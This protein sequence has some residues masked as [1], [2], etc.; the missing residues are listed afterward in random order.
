MRRLPHRKA[1][2]PDGFMAEFLQRCW[3]IVKGDLMAAFAKLFTINGRGFQGLN[4]ALLILLP[5]RPDAAAL[6][7]YRPISLIHM[8]AEVVA[9]TLASRVAPRAVSL[10]DNN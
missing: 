2:G 5:K 1:P 3:G 9:R 6:G 7:D 10:V 8:F 4:L